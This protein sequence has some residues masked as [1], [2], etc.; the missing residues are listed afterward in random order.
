MTECFL[1]ILID[2]DKLLQILQVWTKSIHEQEEYLD[3]LWAQIL[4][5]RSDKWREKFIT[6]HYVAFDGTLAD[7]LQHSLPRYEFLFDFFQSL[8]LLSSC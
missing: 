1:H 6:R 4:K 8:S 5:L 7:A 2:F 3:C